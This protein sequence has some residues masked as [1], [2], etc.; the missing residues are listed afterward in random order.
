MESNLKLYL[1]I[2]SKHDVVPTF[3]IAA[4]VLDKYP[5][6]VK[7]LADIGV[8]FAVHGYEH[9]DYNRL[10][11]EEL[12]RHLEKAIKIFRE[13]NIQFSGFRFPY[14][15][16]DH[17]SIDISAHNSFS[18]DSSHTILW[19]VIKKMRFP[20]T[21]WQQYQA[22]LNQYNYKHSDNY[23][24]L[25]RFINN[26][27]EIPVSLPDDDLLID[28]LG[29]N[30][31]KVLAQ[32]WGEILEQ[33][34]TRGE[35][36]T[37]Q[38]HPE[39]ISYCKETLET[40]LQ[41]AHDSK[42]KIWV[43]PLRSVY[44]WWEE[45]NRFTVRLNGIGDDGYKIEVDCSPRATM[46]VRSPYLEKEDFY[47]GYSIIKERTFWI[48]SQKRPIVGIPKDS[49]QELIQFLKNEGYIFEMSENK[50]KYSL[51]L[52]KFTT[53]S[54]KDE[55]KAL[56]MI[57]SANSSLIRFWRWP[58]GYKSAFAITGDIDCLTIFDFF[59]RSYGN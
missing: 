43:T 18:W 56:D 6:L 12:L 51:F 3:P 29:I 23:I 24:S 14:L 50:K 15:R 47:N 2:L 9:I 45:K 7:N 48:K 44:E 58:N 17:K 38:L 36:F 37:I 21:N 46:L 13:H 53:F 34:Y 1:S 22:M 5:L 4:N 33:T 54:E 57:H 8:E 55:N 49:S 28:R 19:D 40:L 20:R 41:I 52:D 32:I 39:R 11:R 31:E 25:P 42:P 27:L 16:Y 26:I 35:I 59:L 30:D 10:S